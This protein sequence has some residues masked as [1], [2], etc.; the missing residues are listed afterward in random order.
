MMGV[1]GKIGNGFFLEEEVF[2]SVADVTDKSMDGENPAKK[3]DD[4]D[5]D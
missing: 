5:L 3:D 2:L 1:V 4:R